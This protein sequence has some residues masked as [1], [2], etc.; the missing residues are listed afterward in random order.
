MPCLDN[1]LV[2]FEAEEFAIANASSIR[3]GITREFTVQYFTVQY[4]P[5]AHPGLWN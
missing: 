3:S 2:G 4:F 1:F 5:C